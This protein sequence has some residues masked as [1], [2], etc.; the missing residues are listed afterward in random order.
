MY[1]E[2]IRKALGSK[3]PIESL[4]SFAIHLNKKG[5]N[6]DEIYDI[7][8]KYYL[9]LQESSQ[10][11]QEDEDILGDIMDM[12]TGWFVGKNLNLE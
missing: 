6:Q 10:N 12:I 5:M 2:D 4:R 3:D 8:Y 7:F 1:T 9:D 11:L